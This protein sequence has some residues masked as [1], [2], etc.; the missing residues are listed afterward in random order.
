MQH[1]LAKLARTVNGAH[2]E[3]VCGAVY[4]DGSKGGQPPLPARPMAGLQILKFTFDLPDEE[5]CER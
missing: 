1:R 2:P 5:L 4:V 3:D